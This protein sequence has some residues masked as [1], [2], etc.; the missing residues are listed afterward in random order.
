[1]ITYGASEDEEILV[2]S[3]MYEEILGVNLVV[4]G[5]VEILLR[6]KNSLCR[7]DQHTGM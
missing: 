3:V 1:L 4:F 5:E 7:L 6:D 2:Q